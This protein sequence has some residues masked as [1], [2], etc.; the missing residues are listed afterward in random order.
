MSLPASKLLNGLVA[1]LGG[2]LVP[3]GFAPFGWYP[4]TLLGI[5]ALAALLYA[6]RPRDALLIGWLFGIGQFGVGVSWVYISI[7]LYGHASLWLSVAVML[8]LVAFLALFPALMA[9]ALA[10]AALVPAGRFL[11]LLGSSG[12]G[13]TILDGAG[14]YV[15]GLVARQF[16]F[17]QQHRIALH[18]AGLAGLGY[19]LGGLCRRK[20]DPFKRRHLQALA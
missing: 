20:P 17:R 1:L 18:A 6:A 2:A 7:Y 13:P 5:A 3:L 11:A 15:G 10:R 9:W 16:F 19:R 12:C 4:L 14:E 8:L